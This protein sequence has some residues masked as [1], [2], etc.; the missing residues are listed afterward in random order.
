MSD[1]GVMYRSSSS[2]GSIEKYLFHH[3][4][5]HEAALF[6]FSIVSIPRLLNIIGRLSCRVCHIRST[7]PFASGE[8]AKIVFI[9]SFSQIFMYSVLWSLAYSILSS[10]D[11]LALFLAT[12]MKF[13]DQSV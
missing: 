2:S 7:R 6:A 12:E 9:P 10:T 4:H 8:R 5:I 1:G 11:I 3:S 13:L